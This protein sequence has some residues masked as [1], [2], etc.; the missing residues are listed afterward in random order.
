MKLVTSLPFLMA[1]CMPAYAAFVSSIVAITDSEGS[2]LTSGTGVPG[3]EVSLANA[4][5]LTRALTD[6]GFNHAYASSSSTAD[7]Q[8]TSQWLTGFSLFGG[9]NLTFVPLTIQYSYDATLT[10]SGSRFNDA[11]GFSISGNNGAQAG[12]NDV[13][14]VIIISL[15]AANTYEQCPGVTAP[16]PGQCLGGYSAGGSVTALNSFHYG[17][18]NIGG[19]LHVSAA[20]GT[21]D[22]FATGRITGI[23]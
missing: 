1:L 16:L 15:Y 7:A 12:G 10:A 17:P 13:F 19:N 23:R 6:Y 3:V 14:Q 18:N 5:E 4:A 2:A 22:A 20:E 21:V 9:S 8:A 11:F